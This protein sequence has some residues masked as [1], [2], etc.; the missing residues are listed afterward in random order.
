MDV[1]LNDIA[2]IL[3]VPAGA[4]SLDESTLYFVVEK[5]GELLEKHWTGNE[6]KDNV[7]IASGAK[8]SPS[9]KYLLNDDI[10][11]V[12]F[13]NTDYVLQCS[14]YDDSEEWSEVSLESDMPIILHPDSQLSGCFDGQNQQIIFF[15]NPSGQLQGVRILQ[16]GECSALP[17]IGQQALIHTAFTS[18]EGTIHLIYIDDGNQIHNLTL[19]S[20]K[21]A[22]Q[23]T[24]V[25]GRGFG[26]HELT[27]VTATS[28]NKEDLGFLSVSSE[29]RVIY[30]SPQG[31]LRE[32]GHI[33]NKRFAAVSSEECA[34]EIVRIGK[35][36]VKIM[37][38]TKSK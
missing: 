22:W 37:S 31:E 27:R 2:Y 16:T 26:D 7:F 30:L 20:E 36:L 17:E 3:T 6:V 23:D 15:Q 13:P 34:V 4:L 19:D 35:K 8:G 21:G 14:E 25:P 28:T 11:R 18:D 24:P 32:L 1:T 10:R 33:D 12:F 29:K 38:G 9:A 5:D